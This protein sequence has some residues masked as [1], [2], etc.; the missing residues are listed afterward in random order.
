MLPALAL[1]LSATSVAHAED[2]AQLIENATTNTVR[3]MIGEPSTL[4]PGTVRALESL[5]ANWIS[6]LNRLAAAPPAGVIVN[7]DPERGVTVSIGGAN[8][9]AAFDGFLRMMRGGLTD[10][11][12]ADVA[13]A[14]LTNPN[15]HLSRNQKGFISAPIAMAA[16]AMT[17][18]RSDGSM[19]TTLPLIRPGQGGGILLNLGGTGRGIGVKGVPNASMNLETGYRTQGGTT[20]TVRSAVLDLSEGSKATYRVGTGLRTGSLRADGGFIYTRV[21]GSAEPVPGAEGNVAYENVNLGFRYDNGASLSTGVNWA[22][23][24]STS[25]GV[26]VGVSGMGRA[27]IDSPLDGGSLSFRTQTRTGEHTRIVGSVSVGAMDSCRVV[28]SSMSTGLVVADQ[29]QAVAR[30]SMESREQPVMSG[31]FSVEYTPRRTAE[32]LLRDQ[33]RI[34]S[35]IAERVGVTQTLIEQLETADEATGRDLNRRIAGQRA[36]IARLLVRY[37]ETPR[38]RSYFAP[39]VLQRARSLAL[40]AGP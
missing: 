20:W 36:Q 27:G 17:L 23:R 22:N 37:D 13:V 16:L 38:S 15:L 18:A 30:V 11:Q 33:M 8:P 12:L 39:G 5:P 2:P 34:E 1:L 40:P 9:G 4:E 28:T 24:G 26:Q 31:T 10:E 19:S 32:D 25:V 3:T 6:D 14:S 7:H 35:D 29:W 21:P